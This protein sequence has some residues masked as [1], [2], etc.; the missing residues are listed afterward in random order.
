MTKLP[1]VAFGF[2]EITRLIMGHN[3]LCANSHYSDEL[4]REMGE[5][6]TH[7]RVV[8]VLQR[9]EQAGMNT[10]L[11]RGDYHR[12]LYWLE[13]YRR[14]GG[15][16]QCILQTA[17]E[18]HDVFQNIRIL[19]A[20]GPI[21]IY[22]HGTQTDKFWRE[23]RIDATLDYLKCIRDC[24]VMVGLA[25]H[26]PEVIEYAEEHD[27]DVDFYMASFY[28]LSREER[29]SD[30]VKDVFEYQEEQYPDEDRDAMCRVI[31]RTPKTC[32][33]FKILAANRKCGSQEEVSQAFRFAFANIK[34]TDAVVVG[35]FPK[36][37]DQISLN[38]Q[39]T[40]D[41]VKGKTR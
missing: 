1:R 6:F 11:L 38:I 3:P 4:N 10:T 15:T 8:E 23:G 20:A 33:A 28:N 13:L 5:Y 31:R 37:I 35:M 26:I 34:S 21:G 30:I 17:S 12:C 41:A 39:H 7:D 14:T 40:L 9:C 29:E 16:M 19:A 25:T 18:M 27:W 32:L 36:H 22:H 2:H 24:G